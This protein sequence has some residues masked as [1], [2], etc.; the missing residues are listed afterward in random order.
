MNK[1]KHYI[2]HSV[3]VKISIAHGDQSCRPQQLAYNVPMIISIIKLIL[4]STFSLYL[5]VYFGTQIITAIWN[6]QT[7]LLIFFSATSVLLVLTLRAVQTL[8]SGFTCSASFQ[9]AG[10][11]LLA[12]Q[13]LCQLYI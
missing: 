13:A 8:T 4:K 1:H 10:L 11:L 3:L 9:S 7:K 6:S 2:S 12:S 5:Y